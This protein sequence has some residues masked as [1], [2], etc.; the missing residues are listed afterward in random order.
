M[1]RSLVKTQLVDLFVSGM[2]WATLHFARAV[3]GLIV[4]TLTGRYEAPK[5]ERRR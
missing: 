5:K 4:F 3:I 2:P 1:N